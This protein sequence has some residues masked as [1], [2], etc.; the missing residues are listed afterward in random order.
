MKNTRQKEIILDAVNHL[1]NHP[2]ADEI[3]SLTVVR[4]TKTS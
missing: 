3:G 4:S 1:D 2:T